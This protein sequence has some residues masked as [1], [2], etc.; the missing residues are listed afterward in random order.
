[1]CVLCI[2]SSQNALFR[3][4]GEDILTMVTPFNLIFSGNVP[5]IQTHKMTQHF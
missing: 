2:I 4:G 1:M 3:N 5:C